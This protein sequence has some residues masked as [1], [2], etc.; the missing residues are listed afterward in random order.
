MHVEPSCLGKEWSIKPV[1]LQHCLDLGYQQVVWID[2][3]VIVARDFSS[4]ICDVNL[5]TVVVAEAYRFIYFM[6]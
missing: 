6:G 4:L 5:K 1:L 3:D 2:S